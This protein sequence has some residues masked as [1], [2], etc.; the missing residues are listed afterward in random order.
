[1]LYSK[2]KRLAGIAE[3]EARGHVFWTQEFNERIRQRLLHIILDVYDPGQILREMRVTLTRELEIPALAGYDNADYDVQAFIQQGSVDDVA[4]AAE[5]LYMALRRN[6]RNYTTVENFEAFEPAWNQAL[7][8]HRVAFEMVEGVMIEKSSQEIHAEVV[9]P[10]LRLL[11]GSSG[12]ESVEAAY[13]AALSE[14]HEG[15][16]ENAITDAGT[17]LQ[18]ALATLGCKGNALGPLLEDAR[19]KGILAPHDSPMSDA[20][21]RIGDWVSADRSTKGD[22]HNSKPASPED[23]WLTVHV[24]GA[25]ILR[26]A[27]GGKRI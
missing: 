15:R 8:E 5:A 21:K 17:A 13:Q 12:W 24:V 19:A 4:S 3:A 9:A 22:A 18:E 27:T 25:L 23:A 26:L 16:P 14:L 2:R 10:A 7:L 1:M 6:R 20:L 11:S